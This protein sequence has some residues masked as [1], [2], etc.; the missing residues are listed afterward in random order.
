MFTES[1]NIQ[2]K[3]KKVSD[4]ELKLF[5]KKGILSE[6]YEK[7]YIAGLNNDEEKIDKIIKKL[8]DSLK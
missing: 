4:L 1:K 8:E 6:N 3:L 2:K 5:K 7:A